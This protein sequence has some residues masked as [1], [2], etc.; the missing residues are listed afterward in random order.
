ME[1]NPISR[2]KRLGRKT[3]TCLATVSTERLENISANQQKRE[4]WTVCHSWEH[5]SQFSAPNDLCICAALQGEN[6]TGSK[7]LLHRKETAGVARA[8][9]VNSAEKRA[10]M[11]LLAVKSKQKQWLWTCYSF[12]EKVCFPVKCS[13]S[14]TVRVAAG[15]NIFTNYKQL[16]EKCI[17]SKSVILLVSLNCDNWK[18]FMGFPKSQG[19]YHKL[20]EMITPYSPCSCSLHLSICL[21]FSRGVEPAHFETKYFQRV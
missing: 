20:S 1:W 14:A 7:E 13:C 8:R 9:G 12:K 15:R 17:N 11:Q 6:W 2:R 19:Y 10:L 3:A 18:V 5:S 4:F 21:V 16:W